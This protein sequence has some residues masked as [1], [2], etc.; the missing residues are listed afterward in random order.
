MTQAIQILNKYDIRPSVQRIAVI[1]YL[2]KHRTHA[3][4]DV[5]FEAISES[6]PTLSRTTVYNTLRLLSEK[7]ALKALIIEA[8]AVHFDAF[9][10]PHA[11]FLCNVCHSIYDVDFN[12]DLWQKMQLIAPVAT[13]ETQLNYSGVCNKCKN[14]NK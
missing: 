6:I 7:G 8:E 13:C 5:I 10:H 4:A 2:L 9:L 1:D 11:H 14:L 12:D 3:T